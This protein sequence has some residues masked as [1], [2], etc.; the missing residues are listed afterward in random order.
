M[1]QKTFAFI[2]E[3]PSY[4][5]MKEMERNTDN[6]ILKDCCQIG[7]Y[8]GYVG[9]INGEL[10]IQDYTSIDLYGSGLEFEVHGGVT[11]DGHLKKDLPIIPLTAIPVNWSQYRVIGFDC[12]HD[13]DN[14]E[15][16]PLEYV[17][18]QTLNLQA[19]IIKALR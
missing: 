5:N 19:Q 16:C 4:H 13:G 12:G 8:N 2:T 7:R 9:I 17:K 15:N 10:N 6:P 18:E 11:F 14:E 1:K 3:H